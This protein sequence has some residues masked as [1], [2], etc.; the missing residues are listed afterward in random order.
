M[1]GSLIL[2]LVWVI[3]ITTGFCIPWDRPNFWG[4]LYPFLCKSTSRLSRGQRLLRASHGLGWVMTKLVLELDSVFL[5]LL[6]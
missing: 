3:L 5:W 4:K 2:R 6:E 1:V